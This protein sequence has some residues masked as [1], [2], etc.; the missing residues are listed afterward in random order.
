MIIAYMQYLQMPREFKK[1]DKN[2]AND[3]K[4]TENFIKVKNF[5]AMNVFNTRNTQV[6]IKS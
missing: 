5:K 2:I 6:I 4:N 1:K 3:W